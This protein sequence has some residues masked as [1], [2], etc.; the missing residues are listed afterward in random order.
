MITERV[1][2]DVARSG[3]RAVTDTAKR[4]WSMLDAAS[5]KPAPSQYL[6]PRATRAIQGTNSDV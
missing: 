3:T 1:V 4:V 6:S 5:E 2:S